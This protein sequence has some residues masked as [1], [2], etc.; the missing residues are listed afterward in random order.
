MFKRIFLVVM[1]SLGIGEMEDASMFGDS[2]ANTLL[3][4]IKDTY[5][6][7]VLEKLGLTRLIGKEEEKTRGLYMR[8]NTLNKMKDS[9]NG[10]YEMMGI[11]KDEPFEVYKDGFPLELISKIQ[12]TIKRDVIGNIASDGVKII[13]ELGQMHMKTGAVIIYTSCDSVLQVAAHEEIIP[14][15]EL[16]EICEKIRNIIDE[17]GYNIARVIARPFIGKSGDFTRTS[18]RKDYAVDPPK[19]TL[20]LLDKNNIDTI[21]IGKIGDMFNNKNIKV[22]IK[23]KNNIDV[24]MKLIDF[25]KG[26]FNGLLFANLNDFDSDYGHRRDT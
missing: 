5:N 11:I 3:H 23:T 21:C 18:R 26:D 7:D 4:T 25:A 20:T 2:G 6:L 19:N 17:D 12:K 13:E 24:M 8:C 1:D 9:L 14:V 15:N 10:H 16:Y 22:S